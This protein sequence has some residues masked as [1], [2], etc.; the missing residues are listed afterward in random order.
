MHTIRIWRRG[1][2][3]PRRQRNIYKRSDGRWE[4]RY[5][6]EHINGKAKY[7]AVYGHSYSE[8]K[9]KLAYVKENLEENVINNSG[10]ISA[11]WWR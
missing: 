10:T 7:G 1:I 5:I 3:M 9:D 4:G 11:I 2:Y 6:K 8:V